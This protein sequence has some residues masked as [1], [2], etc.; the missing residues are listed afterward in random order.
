M[1]GNAVLHVCKCL[2]PSHVKNKMFQLLLGQNKPHKLSYIYI[3]YIYRV[4][5]F[6]NPGV[7]T[8]HVVT[9]NSISGIVIV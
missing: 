4:L 6:F 5:V 8:P 1:S 2:T 9:W 3:L 7:A